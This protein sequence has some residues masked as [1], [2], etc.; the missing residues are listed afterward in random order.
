MPRI[1]Y[2]N[3]QYVPHAQAAVHVEDRG[4]QFA[5]AV[6]EVWGVIDGALTDFD[7]HLTRLARSLRELEIRQPVSDSALTAVLHRLVSVNRI[8]HGLVY[9][10]ISRGVARRDHVYPDPAVPASIVITVR[11]PPAA[12]AE[13]RARHGISIITRPDERWARR[14]I[15]T[16]SLLPNVIAKQAAHR[17]GAAECWMIDPNGMITEGAAANAWI[18]NADGV[19]VTRP[20]NNDILNGITRRIILALADREGLKTE[21]R[22]FSRDE[23]LQ[24]REAFITSATSYLT[25]VV[26]I[27]GQA[28]GNGHP[29]S[30]SL[31][32]RHSYVATAKE[33][34]RRSSARRPVWLVARQSKRLQN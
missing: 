1:A 12:A 20:A 32:L 10:Q 33:R 29:G 21:E 25:P 13:A 17:K 9:L 34:S 26:Q 31:R 5:D 8:H 22:P 2:V 11:S 6:Y 28:V 4:Y 30:L 23:A 19:L 16:V 15:K 7:G 27:D 14:D 3:G 24:A 18:I